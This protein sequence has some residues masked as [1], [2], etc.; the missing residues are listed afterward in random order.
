M[1]TRDGD[2][3][4][5]ADSGSQMFSVW[6]VAHDGEQEPSA[7]TRTSSALGRERAKK[8]AFLMAHETRG[9]VFFR[10]S[11]SGIWTKL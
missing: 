5:M 11:T 8:L 9:S 6:T 2:V 10:D 7:I 3:V 1:P 4:F